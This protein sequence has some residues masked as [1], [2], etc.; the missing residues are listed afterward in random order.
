MSD[1]FSCQNS[2]KQSIYHK[3]AFFVKVVVASVLLSSGLSAEALWI[4]MPRAQV[5]AVLG[6]PE[7]SLSL[8]HK[9]MLRYPGAINIHLV[10][11]KVQM[12]EGADYSYESPATSEPAGHEPASNEPTLW[13]QWSLPSLR[14]GSADNK[15]PP[16]P[17][18]SPREADNIPL[19]NADSDLPFS[20]EQGVQTKFVVDA[21]EIPDGRL[22]FMPLDESVG[23][24]YEDYEYDIV[25]RNPWIRTS[26]EFL[27][28]LAIGI[29]ILKIAFD[30]EG[31][32][33]HYSQLL[34]ISF[35]Q[36]FTRAALSALAEQYEFI[37]Y[38]LLDIAGSYLALV[39]ALYHFS[40]I[41]QGITAIKIAAVVRA[42]TLIVNLFII[43]ALLL[44]FTF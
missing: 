24:D 36:S 5:I 42:A 27:V 7:S 28:E 43:W 40:Y 13:Q 6:E 39:L 2:Y 23:W 22:K 32:P 44:F 10:E 31:F 26:I 12:V 11:G 30:V 20:L 33:F 4:G 34:K 3:V 14:Q 15:A 19:S 21:P 18:D 25:D 8:N 41:K 29:L 16:T 38:L 1:Y 35:V 9:E 37:T 17:T